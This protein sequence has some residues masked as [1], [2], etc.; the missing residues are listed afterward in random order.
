MDVFAND[1]ITIPGGVDLTTAPVADGYAFI[2]H[3]CSF[4]TS[5]GRYLTE[6]E[7]SAKVSVVTTPNSRV[8]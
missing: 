8:Y 3:V 7:V 6:D 5:L 2:V 1:G 4:D